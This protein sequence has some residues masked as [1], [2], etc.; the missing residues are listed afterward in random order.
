M[1]VRIATCVFCAGQTFEQLPSNATV[2]EGN[3]VQLVC[4]VF[5][6]EPTPARQNT[7]WAVQLPG[8]SELILGINNLS[9]IILSSSTVSTGSDFN[10][11]LTIANATRALDGTRIRCLAIMN[12]LLRSPDPERP[13]FLTVLCEF[14]YLL[15]VCIAGI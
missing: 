11:P 13:A 8:E 2:V 7:V 14:V 12:L 1:Y 3:T 15:V 4:S 5:S 9:E 10:S 6:D